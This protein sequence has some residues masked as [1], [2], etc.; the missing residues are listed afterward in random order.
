MQLPPA[1]RQ[2][3][4]RELEGVAL[5]D[6]TRAADILSQRYRAETRD[7][8]LHLADALAAKAYLT[9]RLPATFAA[10]AAGLAAIAPALPDFHPRSVLD[11]GAG[12]GT[13]T[14]AAASAW[15]SVDEAALVEASPAIRDI[16][17]RLGEA[18]PLRRVVWHAE[19][20][21]AGI[22]GG[23]P[24]DLVIMAYVLDE[25]AP[26]ARGP[27]VARLWELTAGALLLVEPGTTAGWK[28]ILATRDQLLAAGAR[29]LAP[30]PHHKPC[31]LAAPDWCHF[32]AR[33]P[34]SR[35]HRE[36]KGGSVPWEDE[37]FI[38]L[39]AARQESAF[40]SA[41]IIAPTRQSKA[42]IALKLCRPDGSVAERAIAKRDAAAFKLARK[43]G[44]GD[45]LPD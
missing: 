6:L 36:A 21:A 35:L 1:L 25:L 41:R 7:G 11:V 40:R 24:A 14:W 34:R 27:L 29:I 26:P 5:A 42:G 9:T 19:S 18:L 15:D 31:P 23:V 37:K 32:A 3:I 45:C 22:L 39:A 33:V 44:W 38:Y 17:A 4:D 43:R 12:P 10:V 16:G 30:C 28:R 20:V 13:A 2:A 8:R